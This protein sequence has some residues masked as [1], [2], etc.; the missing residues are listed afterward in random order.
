[1]SVEIRLTAAEVARVRFAVSPLAE[2][3]LG[4]RAALGRG[5][6]AVHHA[7]LREARPLLEAEPELPL[8]RALI[9]GCLPSFLFPV[10]HRRLPDLADELAD[11][12]ATPP[13]VFAAEC[14][15]AMGERAAARV[16]PPPEALPRIADALRRCHDLLLAPH[17]GRMRAVLDADVGRRALVL[18]DGGVEGLFAGLH[19]DVAWREGEL[20]VHGRRRTDASPCT[21]EASGHG[22]VLLPSVFSWPDVLVD[23]SPVTAASIRYPA[24]GVGLL[25]ERPAPT[26]GGLDAV[27]GPTRAALLAALAEPLTTSALASRLGVTPSAVS[28]HLGALRSTGLVSTRRQGRGALHLRTE[29]ANALLAP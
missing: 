24:T 4:L 26:P 15:T 1:M 12:R 28:Q 7:W 27:I 14:A 19:Q 3:V 13:A 17:W 5:G 20:L 25:W 16:P 9:G 18:V 23:Q 8:L 21:V 2:T 10:P 11:L 6:H 29:R 22:L